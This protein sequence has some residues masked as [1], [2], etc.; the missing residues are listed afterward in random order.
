MHRR[1]FR[2]G[3]AALLLAAALSVL[4]SGV[5]SASPLDTDGPDAGQSD[6]TSG[7]SSYSADSAGS[8]AQSAYPAPSDSGTPSVPGSGTPANPANGV[9]NGLAA[10]GNAGSEVT[11]DG[12]SPGQTLP[13]GSL[14]GL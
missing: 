12:F 2:T 4:G 10:P 8:S 13:G 5:A 6:S 11:P 3:S 7:D 14:G 9:L 1:L